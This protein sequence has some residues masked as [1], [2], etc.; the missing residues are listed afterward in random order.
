MADKIINILEGGAKEQENVDL[1]IGPKHEKAEVHYIADDRGAIR[2]LKDIIDEIREDRFRNFLVIGQTQIGEK[3]TANMFYFYG[4]S[5]IKLIGLNR[6]M[7]HIIQQYMDGED[8][9]GDFD[10]DE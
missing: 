9:F 4:D 6:R 5:C 10:D 2:T 8:V 7:E 3:A 1:R